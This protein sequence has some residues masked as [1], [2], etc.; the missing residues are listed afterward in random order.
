MK[1]RYGGPT[2]YSNAGIAIAL[3]PGYQEGTWTLALTGPSSE[4]PGGS[5]TRRMTL[6]DAEICTWLAAIWNGDDPPDY[7]ALYEA[8][9]QVVK[10]QAQK[11]AALEAQLADSYKRIQIDEQTRMAMRK[12]IDAANLSAREAVK[13]LT[14]ANVQ[15]VALNKKLRDLEAAPKP[16]GFFSWLR[17]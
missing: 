16:G 4:R 14:D 8:A 5:V 1:Q 7:K 2:L 12:E 9:D 3:E 13:Q 11:V 17:R 6:T 10:Q 15:L